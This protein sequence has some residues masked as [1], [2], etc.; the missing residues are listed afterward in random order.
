MAILLVPFDFESA[1]ER[2]LEFAKSFAA[3]LG[4][5]VVLVHVY[6]LPV[7]T[8]PGFEPLAAPAYY[9]EIAAA[10]QRA[11]EAA[12]QQA[13]GVRGLLREGD[14]ARE[15]LAA[16]QETGAELVVMG[17]HGRRGLA[18]LLLGSVTEKVVRASPVPVVTVREPSH[19]H[20]HR[21][22]SGQP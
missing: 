3:R 18:H 16:V 19:P 4:D 14:P 10:A 12:C 21:A 11:L 13:G 20:A 1:S 6:Q 9:P 5:E 7:Y 8:Y 15:I 22:P 17:T 2:A